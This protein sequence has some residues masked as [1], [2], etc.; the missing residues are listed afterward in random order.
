MPSSESAGISLA[1]VQP[2]IRVIVELGY[3]SALL[4]ESDRGMVRSTLADAFIDSAAKHFDDPALG[5]TV[6]RRIPIGGLGDLDYALCT[7]N[8]LGEGLARLQRFYGLATQRVRLELTR[9]GS[10]ARLVFKRPRS[11]A[12]S[13]HWVEFAPAMV[14]ERMRQTVGDEVLFEEVSFAHDAPRD[15]RVHDAFFG[16][17]VRFSQPDD[18]L[19]FAVALLERPLR[20][21]SRAL[22]EVLDVRMKQLEPTLVPTD[23][24]LASVR[25]AIVELLDVKETA[26]PEVAARLHSTSRTLQ[27]QL[28][29]NGTSHRQL[30]DEIR[31]ERALEFLEQG[32]TI[33]EV[34][35]SLGFSEPSAFF[36]AFR[37]W[38]GTSPRAR[39]K[40]PRRV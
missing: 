3:P 4:P 38:T 21:M 28:R 20:T 7:S 8:T 11:V 9:E 37:R 35:S 12:Q 19:G 40:E 5:L 33:A 13:R 16:T 29:E 24:L 14:A 17:R 22:A 30:L 10:R 6:A 23:P 26:L 27:R 39:I 31:Q 1:I 25:R 36:R 18:V 34:A 32:R 15:S 2:V